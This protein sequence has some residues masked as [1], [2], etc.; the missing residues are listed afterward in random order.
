MD[1]IKKLGKYQKIVLLALAVIVVVFTV[2]YAVEISRVGY[3]Y[4]GIIF[5]PKKNNGK[6]VYSASYRG[7]NAVLLYLKITQ[8]CLRRLRQ[9]MVHIISKK[10]HQQYQLAVGLRN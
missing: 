8:S 5:V 4:N 1:R 10:I 2:V 7:R 3:L 6:V 9:N